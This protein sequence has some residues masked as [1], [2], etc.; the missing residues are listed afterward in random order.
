MPVPPM[1]ETRTKKSKYKVN[2][3]KEK[4]NMRAEMQEMFNLYLILGKFLLISVDR[5]DSSPN[6]GT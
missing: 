4:N 1:E 5:C 3:R 2:R 6:K